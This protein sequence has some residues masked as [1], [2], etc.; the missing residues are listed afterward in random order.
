MAPPMQAIKLNAPQPT[1]PGGNPVNSRPHRTRQ[2]AP[3]QQTRRCVIRISAIAFPR[4]ALT[5]TK[6]VTKLRFEAGVVCH[7]TCDRAAPTG[8][9]IIAWPEGCVNRWHFARQRVCP[10]GIFRL[11]YGQSF[12]S[13][14]FLPAT[15]TSPTLAYHP[16][17]TRPTGSNPSNGR[18]RIRHPRPS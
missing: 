16:S 1:Q 9:S 17:P 12:S 15:S 7:E 11:Q 13:T 4:W 14:R 5:A 8:N 6:G 2:I 10:G 18:C 3:G